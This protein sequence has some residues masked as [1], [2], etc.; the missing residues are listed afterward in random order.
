MDL[1]IRYKE[2]LINVGNVHKRNRPLISLVRFV[3][4]GFTAIVHLGLNHH[5]GLV[6]GDVVIAGNGDSRFCLSSCCLVRVLLGVVVV[7]DMVIA[8]NGDSIQTDSRFQH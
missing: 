2:M 8:G 7:R 3:G 6:V 4:L 5:L 1:Q